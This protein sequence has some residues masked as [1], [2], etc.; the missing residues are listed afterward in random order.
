M[1][2]D[3]TILKE[4]E[5]IFVNKGACF[6]MQQIKEGKLKTRSLA[7]IKKKYKIR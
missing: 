7:E 2:I 4:D 5:L 6:E 3:E 1:H